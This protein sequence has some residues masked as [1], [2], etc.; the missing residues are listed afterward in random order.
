M[1]NSKKEGNYNMHEFV[2][3]EKEE[4]SLIE[5]GTNWK[6][7]GATASMIGGGIG[8]G[9]TP[10]AFVVGGPGAGSALFGLSCAAMDYGTDYY[11]KKR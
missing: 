4:L 3:C 6:A 2:L 8:I 1:E 5:G 9:L 11:M 10:F 7:V